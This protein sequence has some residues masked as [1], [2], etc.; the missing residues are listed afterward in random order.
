MNFN[1]ES[2][3]RKMLVKYPFFGTV[4]ANVEDP[5]LE[6]NLE[7]AKEITKRAKRVKRAI[8][9]RRN[10]CLRALFMVLSIVREEPV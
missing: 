3:K 1:I 9:Q 10:D 8:V 7:N 5:D 4:V 2:I 6:I